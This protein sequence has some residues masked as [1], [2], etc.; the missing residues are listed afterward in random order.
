[1]N[2]QFIEHPIEFI[3]NF[4]RL[5]PKDAK[6]HFDLYSNTKIGKNIEEKMS[7]RVIEI[8]HQLFETMLEKTTEHKNLSLTSKVT[9]NGEIFHIPIVDFVTTDI[10]KIKRLEEIFNYKIKPSYYHS[11]KSYH[12][13]VP[14]L[15]NETQWLD[16]M[17]KLLLLNQENDLI[18][19]PRWVG[20]RLLARKATL[21]LNEKPAKIK[22]LNKV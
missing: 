1:M 7:F 4:C 10:D 19:S 5:L 21:R 8:N 11:G 20:H 18:I 17:A 22:M 3:I 9:I 16:F 14:K 2:S 6:L 12:A 15:L 13:Y